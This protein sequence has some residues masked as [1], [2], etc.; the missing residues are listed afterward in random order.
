[1]N[2]GKVGGKRRKANR[3][4]EVGTAFQAVRSKEE[5]LT[6]IG[7]TAGSENPPYPGLWR[8][9]MWTLVD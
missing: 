6:S 5:I 1:M 7:S 9:E 8:M 4:M 3:G 2:K